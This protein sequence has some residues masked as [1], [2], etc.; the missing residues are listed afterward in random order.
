MQLSTL[1]TL[2][3]ATVISAQNI[4]KRYTATSTKQ[5]T[6]DCPFDVAT[7][8]SL[9]CIVERTTTIP[10]PNPK[11][12]ITPTKIVTKPCATACPAG[13]AT[14][15]YSEIGTTTCDCFK[16]T[17]TA[18]SSECPRLPLECPETTLKVKNITTTIPG[19]NKFCPNTTTLTTFTPCQ[20]GCPTVITEYFTATRVPPKRE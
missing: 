19:P 3:L 15:T 5:I 13:C 12:P 11:V 4:C 6:Q 17:V 2:G 1:V 7:C 16:A 18:E 8:V 9:P 10:G 14:T 20:T